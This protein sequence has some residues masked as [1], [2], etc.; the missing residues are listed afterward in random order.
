MRATINRKL[1]Y[2]KKHICWGLGLTAV[3]AMLIPYLILGLDS[4]V[5]YLDQLDGEMISYILHSR[6]LFQGNSFPEFMGGTDKSALVMPAP[7]CVLFF[8]S[9]H[10]FGAYVTMQLLGSLTGFCGMY[11]LGRDLTGKQWIGMIVGVLYA[12]LPFLPVY[13]L[14]QYGIPLLIWCFWQMQKGEKTVRCVIYSILY[15]F[16]SSLVLVG[17]AVMGLLLLEMICQ[18]KKKIRYPLIAWGAMLVVYVLENLGLLLQILSGHGVVSHKSEYVL[19]PQPFLDLLWQGFTASGQHTQDF[20]SYIL[21]L[22][23]GILI[24]ATVLCVKNHFTPMETRPSTKKYLW[25]MCVLLGINFA[26]SCAA[27][28]WGSS[29]GIAFR[30][31]MQAMK[32]FQLGRVLWVTSALWYMIL[33]CILGMGAELAESI[34]STCEKGRKNIFRLFNLIR[35]AAISVIGIVSCLTAAR[36][37]L[38][39]NL[40]PN[41]QKVMDPGYSMLSYKD[42]YALDGVMDQVKEYLDQVSGQDVSRYRVVSLGIDP[43]AAYYHGFYCL[44]GYSNNYSLDYKE[45]FR[46]IIQPELDK[47][48]YLTDYYDDWGN[49]CYLFSAEIPGY[50][51]V[52]K[53]GFYFQNYELNTQALRDLGGRYLLSAAYIMNAEEQ[54]LYLMRE[55]P[56]EVTDSYYRIFVY[57]VRGQ[58]IE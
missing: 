36:I 20:H 7:M 41:L 48:A 28:F 32:G 23:V 54:G 15:A 27:A 17:F 3:F 1:P 44:D 57:E 39:S 51:T 2:W 6:H 33:A 4:I 21:F 53:N 8:L 42:Y 19:T 55:D 46:K 49:R 9:G 58:D 11:L 10:Y 14:S 22:A 43:A 25:V 35:A 30:S 18:R 29:A 52:E 50:Y 13:G 16:N 31:Q 38:A 37:L 34:R 56:F 40:K 24:S 12:Y 45:T 47:S 26:L 5:V